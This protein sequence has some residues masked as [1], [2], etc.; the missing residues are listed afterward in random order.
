MIYNLESTKRDRNLSDIFYSVSQ[1][2]DPRVL[3]EGIGAHMQ[4]LKDPVLTRLNMEGGTLQDLT[5]F[6]YRNT[7]VTGYLLNKIMAD[8][9]GAAD[10]KTGPGSPPKDC[11]LKVSIAIDHFKPTKDEVQVGPRHM[12]ETFTEDYSL[13]SLKTNMKLVYGAEFDVIVKMQF[14]SRDPTDLRSHMTLTYVGRVEINATLSVPQTQEMWQPKPYEQQ[15]EFYVGAALN[16][17]D[18][19]A[20]RTNAEFQEV[21]QITG[22]PRHNKS[23]EAVERALGALANSV[24]F[25]VQYLGQLSIP[26]RQAAQYTTSIAI[27]WGPVREVA[28][29]PELSAGRDVGSRADYQLI[30]ETLGNA[31]D[32][33][34]S[35]AI[36]NKPK[37]GRLGDLVHVLR[38]LKAYAG[39]LTSCYASIDHYMLRAFW[40]SVGDHN[41]VFAN[42]ATLDPLL[43]K[44]A[45]CLARDANI[46]MNSCQIDA[47]G[48]SVGV[49]VRIPSETAFE[50]LMGIPYTD[51][52]F[53]GTLTFAAGSKP[54]PVQGA[55]TRQ[56]FVLPTESDGGPRP[57]L[58]VSAKSMFRT[59]PVVVVIGTHDGSNTRA[60]TAFLLLDAWC[61]KL[62]INVSAVP[63]N[64]EFKSQMTML[65]PEMESFAK[66]I[67][68]CDLAESG[69][70]LLIIPLRPIL[71]SQ[72]G[73]QEE[74]LFGE[75][76]W[77]TQLVNLMRG[78]TSLHAIAQ[79]ET[80]RRPTEDGEFVE[81]PSSKTS[82]EKINAMK[83]MTERLM[84]E[85]YKEGE[86]DWRGYKPPEK[87]SEKKKPAPILRGGMG[88]APA[89]RSLAAADDGAVPAYRGLA[90]ADDDDVPASRYNF[91]GAVAPR[92]EPEPQADMEEPADME[93]GDGQAEVSGATKGGDDAAVEEVE[94]LMKGLKADDTDKNFMKKMM[95]HCEKGLKNTE[96]VLG[97]T[98]SIPNVTEN[99]KFAKGKLPD[100]NFFKDFVAP[101]ADAK[102]D[103]R[104]NLDLASTGIQRM[105]LAHAALGKPVQMTRLSV[106]GVCVAWETNLLTG[107]M[108]GTTKDPTQNIVNV[109]QHLSK[110]QQKL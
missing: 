26:L 59:P 11:I 68:A 24:D 51:N 57:T 3:Q 96:S 48:C 13:K 84:N 9:E 67:R 53:D 49:K 103:T 79:S 33:F 27:P 30:G 69:L 109:M 73:I 50:Q 43:N 98:L 16:V 56:V 92:E 37:F 62:D 110:L 54:I 60:K 58:Q 64:K 28:S 40:K 94:Q 101:A 55:Y 89:Y 19:S 12:T 4:L 22:M 63:S 23:V 108:A 95:D 61:M 70:D 46:T 86:V 41:K 8:L 10:A 90:A 71:A 14:R 65:P 21:F 34:H 47:P 106:F 15:K 74:D 77:L 52:N 31:L 100:N 20:M 102:W 97:A 66:A 39:H 107:M 1:Q 36:T 45:T 32:Q 18:N 38:V 5:N 7:A 76:D 83:A 87:P 80:E 78:G 99:C 44:V 85:M 6:A 72:L 2:S 104:A 29:P 91:M 17:Q 35:D 42:F 93:V 75:V 105:L 88:G 81:V 25:V 82:L